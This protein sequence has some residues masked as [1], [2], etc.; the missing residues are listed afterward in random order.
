MARAPRAN[1]KRLTALFST[2]CPLSEL[3]APSPQ[4]LFADFGKLWT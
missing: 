1:S 2:W 4:Y 3:R